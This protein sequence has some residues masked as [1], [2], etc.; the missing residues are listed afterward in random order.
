MVLIKNV[1]TTSKG[2]WHLKTQQ[3]KCPT[4]VVEVIPTCLFKLHDKLSFVWLAP[5]EV[6]SFLLIFFS[7]LRIFLMVPNV[8]L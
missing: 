4:K 2:Y 5:K 8:H 3:Y 6:N 1:A 7:N